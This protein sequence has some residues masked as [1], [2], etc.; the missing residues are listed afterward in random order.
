MPSKLSEAAIV[1]V[2]VLARVLASDL[3]RAR[4]IGLTR[5]LRLACS[6]G[7]PGTGGEMTAVLAG[8]AASRAMLTASGVLT[9]GVLQS[10][11]AEWPVS[12]WQA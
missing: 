1:S 9:A 8:H 11:P 10:W 12:R 3:G 5:I 4:K 7:R 6:P 2:A